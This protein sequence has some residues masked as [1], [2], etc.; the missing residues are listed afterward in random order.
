MRDNV[1]LWWRGTRERGDERPNDAWAGDRRTGRRERGTCR[2]LPFPG[3]TTRAYHHL[4][5]LPLPVRPYPCH[6]S[7]HPDCYYHLYH[8]YRY[9]HAYAGRTFADAYRAVLLPN[10]GLTPA[11]GCYGSSR[12]SWMRTRRM[13]LAV[14]NATRASLIPFADSVLPT[15]HRLT[16]RLL[17]ARIYRGGH[18]RSRSSRLPTRAWLRSVPVPHL[19]LLILSS[20]PNLRVREN[21]EHRRCAACAC[22]PPV[23]SAL[24]RLPFDAWQT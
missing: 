5:A 24:P 23:P 7:P 1:A 15:F 20:L 21:C 19:I 13:L 2:Y 11:S 22:L 8:T 3:S 17:R 9:S 10:L 6:R 12:D 16:V 4:P 14:H 18:R